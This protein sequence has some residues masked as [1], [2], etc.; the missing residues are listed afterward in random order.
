MREGDPARRRLIY[1]QTFSQRASAVADTLSTRIFVPVTIGIRTG[2]L[3]RSTSFSFP[4]RIITFVLLILQMF[5]PSPGVLRAL[6]VNNVFLLISYPVLIVIFAMNFPSAEIFWIVK[7]LFTPFH[8]S[9]FYFWIICLVKAY[10]RADAHFLR[11]ILLSWLY[12]PY[13][14]RKVLQGENNASSNCS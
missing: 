4:G 11:L 1:Q 10:P 14:Y 7:V 2:L 8:I 3:L 9:L 5:S 13:F 12:T 6:Y